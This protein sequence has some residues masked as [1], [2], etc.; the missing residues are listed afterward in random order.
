MTAVLIQLTLVVLCIL[1]GTFV[2]KWGNNLKADGTQ[3]LLDLRDKVVLIP[4]LFIVTFVLFA[5]PTN[6][7][8]IVIPC[9][10]YAVYFT[11]SNILMYFI[12]RHKHINLPT[13]S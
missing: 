3:C 10:V 5:P 4:M 9:L 6:P 11:L 8:D 1:I 7:Y 13:E 12:I 2:H